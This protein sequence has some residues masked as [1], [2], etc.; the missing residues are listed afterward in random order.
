MLET[1]TGAAWVEPWD[2]HGAHDLVLQLFFPCLRS[3][4]TRAVSPASL[5]TMSAADA[6]LASLGEDP[7][8][9]SPL[10]SSLTGLSLASA[11]SGSS[12]E[13]GGGAKRANLLFFNDSAVSSRLCLGFVGSGSRR[14]C[15]K[16]L[17]DDVS[18]TCGVGK[19]ARKFEPKIGHFFLKV[20]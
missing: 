8:V 13:Y 20:Q 5:L 19:H 16:V 3:F 11:L 4:P 2:V 7:T 1:E 10:A 18:T 12:G 15:L 9:P 17:K 14:F 6:W